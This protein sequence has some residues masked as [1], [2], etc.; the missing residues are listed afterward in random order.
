MFI[1]ASNDFRH[2]EKASLDSEYR[3]NHL[4]DFIFHNK[5]ISFWSENIFKSMDID[6]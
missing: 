6:V 5:H 3:Q 4:E 2:I 1:K